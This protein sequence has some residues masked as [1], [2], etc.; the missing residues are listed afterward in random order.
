MNS[1]R[2]NER[3]IELMDKLSSIMLKQGEPFR[4]KAY[5]KAQ[6]TI[7]SFD[8]D[9]YSPNDLKNKKGIGKTIF[10]K[11]VEYFETG[12]LSILEIEKTNPVNILTD[13]YGIGPKKAK[14]LV[15]MGICSVS[16]LRE[17]Q[18]LLNKN[19]KLGLKYYE[20]ILKRIPREEIEEYKTYFEMS[21]PSGQM[22]IVGSY[23]RGAESSGDIDVIITSN[24]PA[25]F[26]NFIENLTKRQI[27]THILSKGSTK[28]LVISKIPSSNFYRRVDLLFTSPEEFPFAILYFTGSKIFNTIMRQ[29]AVN[30]G[31]TM[32]EHGIH[33]MIG[34]VKG[35]KVEQEFK[36]EKDIFDF[37]RIEYKHPVERID[38]RSVVF[39]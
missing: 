18:Q 32:N 13:I 30:N 33:H 38:G 16:Q 29:V 35:N 19:Q 9:I 21:L 24:N 6:E 8:A 39:M 15:D 31:Y 34:K 17:N 11:L 26:E 22:E 25:D 36:T 10:E 7:M 28:C 27:I 3:Y 5:Q 1:E 37:L 20:D 12:T 14:D 2:L 4:A 23:R